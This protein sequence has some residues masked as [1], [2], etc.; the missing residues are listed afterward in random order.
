MT[1]ER[2]ILGIS[3]KNQILDS[4]YY[5]FLK[6]FNCP[7]V[8][9]DFESAELTKIAINIY[10]I[11]SVTVTNMMSNISKLIGSEWDDVVSALKLDRR[12]GKYAYLSPGLGISGGNLER[13]LETIKKISLNKSMEQ[14]FFKSF[15]KISSYMKQW[16]YK[17]FIKSNQEFQK[18]KQIGILG[19]SYK[20]NTNSIKNSPSISFIKNVEI[21]SKK[22]NKEIKI[23]VYD[24]VVKNDKINVKVTQVSTVNKLI[25]NIDALFILTPWKE[26]NL[27][28]K[29]MFKKS[30]IKYIVD[31]FKMIKNSNQ[32][33][34]KYHTLN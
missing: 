2:I 3:E 34:I 14:Y 22:N 18:I 4:K 28:A 31:P 27:D 29:K 19:L 23:K 1:P 7:I 32:L 25:K 15:S 30:N 20:E 5:N 13:D 17:I 16:P 6:S 8:K 10:L 24:P 21:Y 12:I 26:F 33:K 11:S 9:M